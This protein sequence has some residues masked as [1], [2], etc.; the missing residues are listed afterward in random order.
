MVAR[1]VRDAEVESSSLSAPTASSSR[2]PSVAHV[3]IAN[4]GG[5]F[6]FATLE[7]LFYTQQVGA[8]LESP[9]SRT[10]TACKLSKPLS[11]FHRRGDGYQSWCKVCRR[12]W[13]AAYHAR[14]RPISLT[15]KRARQ[16]GLIAWMRE[17]KSSRPCTDCGGWFHPAAMTFDHLRGTSKRGDV[18]NLLYAGYRKVLLDEIAKCELVCA[19]CHAVRTFMRETQPQTAG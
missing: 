16:Q 1:S 15:Q 11:E 14:R 12:A 3:V 6:E 13:D 9:N 10:C 5:Q 8:V 19:N 18:S 7:R 17:L 2:S 4:R